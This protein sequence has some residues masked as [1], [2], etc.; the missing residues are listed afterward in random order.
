[1]AARRDGE[2]SPNNLLRG[3]Y[4]LLFVISLCYS[5][6]SHVVSESV[7]SCH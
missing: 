3:N 2:K 6:T 7:S 4:L 1:M 5:Y